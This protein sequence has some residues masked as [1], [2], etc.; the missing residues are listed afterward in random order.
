MAIIDT[1]SPNH[2]ERGVKQPVDMLVLHYTGMVDG[3]S[4]LDRLRDPIAKVSAHYL[5]E[6]DGRVFR[7]VPEDRR[8][9]HA[10]V[11]SWRG[12]RDVN[13][14]SVGIEIVNPGHEFGYRPFPRAQMRAVTDLSRA[15]LGRHPIPARNVVGHSD[16]APARKSDPGEL[17]DWHGLAR[18]GVGAWPSP[19][20]RQIRLAPSPAIAR[21]LL[22]RWGYG[23]DRMRWRVALT[24]FQR[25]FRPGRVDGALDHECFA[26]LVDLCLGAERGVY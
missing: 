7:L 11:S 23:V 4:A 15:I 12:W 8:A 22:R 26:V 20:A 3:P 13:A 6:E 10:G 16:V 17:F 18:A 9:W 14:R 1:P 19:R 25:H 24:A 2:D 21:G 5:V